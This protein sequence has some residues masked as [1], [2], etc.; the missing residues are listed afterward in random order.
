M[1][2]MISY[3]LLLLSCFYNSAIMVNHSVIQQNELVIQDELKNSGSIVVA[4][5]LS[6]YNKSENSGT[7]TTKKLFLNGSF[8]NSGAVNAST[9]YATA[10]CNRFENQGTLTIG[11]LYLAAY[12]TILKLSL[13]KQTT[14]GAV[15]RGEE[16]LGGISCKPDWFNNSKSTITITDERGEQHIFTGTQKTLEEILEKALNEKVSVVALITYLQQMT[17][18]G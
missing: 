1:K 5:S 15:Y 2:H 11:K 14:I 16:F 12:E 18:K 17:K 9:V 7:I 4:D 8:N 13:K 3:F 6:L 10:G